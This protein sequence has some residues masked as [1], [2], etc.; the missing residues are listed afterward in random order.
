VS[1]NDQSE[2]LVR[3]ATEDESAPIASVLHQAFREFE[4]LYTPEGFAATTPD[5][6]IIRQRWHEGPVWVALQSGNIVGTVSALPR[7]DS[8]YVR[9]MAV[10]PHTRG[11]GVGRAL[12]QEVEKFATFQGFHRI[13]LSTTPFLDGAIKLYLRYGFRLT[14]EG[15]FDLHGTPLFTMEK[16]LKPTTH[17]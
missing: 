1:S 13:F 5:S 2:F 8:L 14:N 7:G 16:L 12:L 15:P 9:S 3:L 10:L 4:P 11:L 6:E 17:H